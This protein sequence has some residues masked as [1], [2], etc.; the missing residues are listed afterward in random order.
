[1]SGGHD[2]AP[3]RRPPATAAHR[4]CAHHARRTTADALE[5]ALGAQERSGLRLGAQLVAMGAV[6]ETDVTHALARQAGVGFLTR[7][8][9]DDVRRPV[10]G[11]SRTVVQALGVVPLEVERD[12]ALRI[13]VSA[14]L[15]RMAIATLQ[16]GTGLRIRVYL[17]ADSLLET[18]LD[19]YGTDAP[20]PKPPIGVGRLSA[21][22][23][24]RRIADA[25]GE[26]RAISWR[27]TWGPGFAWVRVDGA[28]GPED[29][30][31]T[32]AT[33]QTWQEALTQR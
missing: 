6:G 32:P 20:A 23:A 25:A 8:D 10:A 17:V 26:G 21:E 24:A 14:P 13:A 1:M 2:G 5:R 28:S 27:Y 15:P 29:L 31:V 16:S 30:I 11:L 18:L 3:P 9:P 19:A 22:Q 12:G 7:V 4:A 33:E